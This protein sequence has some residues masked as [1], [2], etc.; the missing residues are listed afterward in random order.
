M[1]LQ[2]P[3]M[4]D[5]NQTAS[6]L[7][8]IHSTESFGLVDG[9]GVR[10]VIFMQGCPMRCRF[11]HNPDTW[12]IGRGTPVSAEELLKKALRFSSYWKQD[13]GITVSGGEPMV[14]MDF[15]TEL[16]TLAKAEG[17]H[18]TLDTSGILFSKEPAVF[19]KIQKLLAVTDLILLDIK[20]I[21][22]D[23]HQ[24]LTGHSNR[25][26]LSFAQYLS[27]IG[28]PVWIRHVLVPGINDS[29]DQLAR[30]SRFVASL[31]NVKR[32]EVLP[33]HTLGIPK[34][35][36]LNLSYSLEDVDPPSDELVSHAN[37]ILRTADYIG[38]L[39][40]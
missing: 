31:S 23:A 20:H 24:S 32:F 7:G 6:T 33:Y 17:I 12:E 18:T 30:L 37:K 38:Y 34:W 28:K 3:A 8:F 19:G 5:C 22:D 39:D 27:E 21:D 9:P 14:Q 29:D 2:E 10:F 36:K 35:K 16:F 13:G 15:L 40:K 4:T 1:S 26:I 11:C 25:A